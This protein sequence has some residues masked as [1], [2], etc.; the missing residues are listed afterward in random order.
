MDNFAIKI[1]LLIFVLVFVLGCQTNQKEIMKKS[2]SN[3]F[4]VGTYTDSV[5]QGIYKCLLQKDGI[6]KK[7]G[8]AAKSNNPSFLAKSS[9]QKYL[10][11][12]SE[13]DRNSTGEIV[14]FLIAGDSLQPISSSSSGGAHPCFVSVNKDGFVLA[15][16]Y[17]GGNVGLLRL[18]KNG[19]LSS[20]LDV[21]QHTG[22]GSTERQQ[23]PHAHSAWFNPLDNNIIS[24]DLGTN[25]LWFSYLDTLEQKLIP[26][27]PQ[28]LS[29]DP[30]AGPRH[31]AFHP[32]NKWIY[33]INELNSTI[34]LVEKSV[35]N[36]YKKF[37]SISTLPNGYNEPSFC[38]DIHISSDGKFVYA[39]NRGHNSIAIFNVNDLD[40]S[41]RLVN[42]NPCGGSWP[43]NFSLSPDEEYLLVANQKT[44][45]IVS[46]KRDKKT[47]LLK[48]SSEIEAPNPVCIL[49]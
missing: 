37:S 15:A 11:A 25:E 35:E 6:L 26:S 13:V 41:L 43:R 33:V 28:K 4:Y 12:V 17:T 18:N 39:S 34:T 2:S 27:E 1:N 20:L 21:E 47:G 36:K 19:E 10:L 31:L 42:I 48:Y 49:F 16:N 3:A 9:D 30:G 23:A 44:N 5:S 14:S 45:N 24:I 29:M 32:N 22:K 8:L 7:I 40:G 38:A 46:F